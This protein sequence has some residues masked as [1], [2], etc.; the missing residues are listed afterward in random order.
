MVDLLRR[1]R[2]HQAG[3][4]PAMRGRYGRRH[5]RVREHTRFEQLPPEQERLLERADEHR[6]DGRLGR[7]DVE[8]ERAQAV[9]EPARV[10]P[11]ALATLG[12]ALTDV[13][14]GEHACR[15]RR[16]TRASDDQRSG[17]VLQEVDD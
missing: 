14:R 15:V 9:L 12:L 1:V 16:R 6:Y 7:A 10:L 2:R 3:A 13:E 4:Q 5:Y 17:V 8:A 11:Q